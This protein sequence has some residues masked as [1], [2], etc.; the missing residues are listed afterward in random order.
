MLQKELER[1]TSRL[2]KSYLP[3]LSVFGIAMMM[4]SYTAILVVGYYYF[5]VVIKNPHATMY[6]RVGASL[7]LGC[8]S[9]P[10]CQWCAG[11]RFSLR[12]GS[13]VNSA[14]MAKL[15]PRQRRLIKNTFLFAGTFFLGFYGCL[16]FAAVGFPRL[17]DELNIM[18]HGKSAGMK[19][20]IQSGG[21]IVAT[22][23]FFS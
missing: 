8:L 5:F 7:Y 13:D 23:L 10:L 22:T 2:A 19:F 4:G 6:V 3:G 21:E 20:L 14:W 18:C 12:N 1:K 9:Y 16:F 11:R 17:Q 15:N